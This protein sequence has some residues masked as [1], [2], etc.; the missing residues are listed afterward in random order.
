MRL[1][2]V[3][4]HYQ[5]LLESGHPG[6]GTY[7]PHTPISNLSSL[8]SNPRVPVFHKTAHHLPLLTILRFFLFC[9][10]LRINSAHIYCF[11]VLVPILQPLLCAFSTPTPQTGHFSSANTYSQAPT[12]CIQ[13][14]NTTNWPFFICQHLFPSPYCAHS[15]PQHH[16][17]AIFI[18]QHLFPSPYY[19]CSA[20]QHHKLAIFHL[21]TPIPKPLLCMF[22]T[23]TP[24]T[25]H[26]S[27]ANTYSQAPTTR[28]QHP[29]TTNWPFFA[30]Q[31]LV[32]IILDCQHRTP[33]HR[34]VVSLRMLHE[35]THNSLHQLE[36]EE[37][38]SQLYSD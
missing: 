26:F 20:P 14:P 33:L 17:L 11:W 31:H 10:T 30:C 16:K 23:P 29:N 32:L 5:S 28:I 35:P 34:C 22:G 1:L 7:T 2:T 38:A 3:N 21:A 36:A 6:F 25:G 12:A 27:F 8:I 37:S 24:Q 9:H 19:A 4:A 18:C 15:A 13:H